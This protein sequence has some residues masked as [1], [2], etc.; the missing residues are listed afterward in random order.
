MHITVVMVLTYIVC[1]VRIGTAPWRYFQLNAHYFSDEEG[2]FSKLSIDRLIPPRWRLPQQPD[3]AE[4]V[5]ASFPVFLKPE[6]GQN[7]HGI[8]RADSPDELARI[9][10]T[11]ADEP[12]RYLLQE[13]APGALEFEIFGIDADR[14]DG[15][16]DVLTVTEAVNERERFPINSKYNRHTRYIEITP[17]FSDDERQALSGFLSRIGRFGISR[18]SVRADSRQAL[19]AGQ[20]KVIEINLFLPM[21]INLL[22]E[23]YTVRARWRFIRHAMMALAQSTRLIKRVPRERAIFTRMMM[24]GRSR[25]VTPPSRRADACRAS[26][27][28]AKT[29]ARRTGAIARDMAGG[30]EICRRERA[31]ETRF[32][33][34]RSADS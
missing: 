2:I 20:F 34:S 9:R 25:A 17:E 7:A 16:H 27:G 29:A 24:Y 11:L 13:A 1:C 28:G 22:D 8:H 6:W 10:A 33:T 32:E 14:S 3:S 23:R 26:A 21:P 31:A 4:L 19:L 12:K 30:G 18:M 5:P 15:V